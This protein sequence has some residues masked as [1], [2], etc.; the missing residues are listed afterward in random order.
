[1]E[2]IATK[3]S[4]LRKTHHVMLA[5][6]DQKI[7]QCHADAVEIEETV[8][9]AAERKW[10]ITPLRAKA[11]MIKRRVVFYSKIKAALAM[12]YLI[13]PN[14]DCTLFAIRTKKTLP[15]TNNV[16]DYK[17]SNFDEPCQMLPS[18]EGQYVSPTPT[19]ETET[20]DETDKNGKVATKQHW[21]PHE[22]QEVEFPF[23]LAKPKL[24]NAT[25]RAMA[26]KL[27]DEVGVVRHAW[28]TKGDPIIVGIIRNP[29]RSRPSVTFF[30]SW[31]F[32]LEAL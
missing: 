10:K 18:G 28:R 16:R 5:W 7:A 12:G 4:E 19:L 9:T 13:I 25:S 6:C 1:M 32:D 20:Y 15:N 23:D 17:H 22:F 26:A 31:N 24:M 29:N 2:L 11:A 3:P 8:K 21:W 14:L 30:V 27:F